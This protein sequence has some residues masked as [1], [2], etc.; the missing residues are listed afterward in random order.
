MSVP[1]GRVGLA[2]VA[3]VVVLAVGGCLSV[4]AGSDGGDAS[5]TTAQVTPTTDE[6]GD[7]PA[8]PPSD[9]GQSA[10]VTRV[11]DGDT[12][13]VELADGTVEK[14]RL[15]GVDT[16]E[17]YSENTPD[18]YGVPDTQAGRDC[19]GRYGD[20][21]SEFAVER[22]AG[23]EVR[24]VPDENLDERGYYGRLLA[25][26]YVDGESFN[27]RLIQEGYARVFE[28]DFTRRSAYE[29][30][31]RAARDADRGL[32]EC[33]TDTDAGTTVSE[34]GLAVATVNADAEG[35]DGENLNDE[36]VVFENVGSESLSLQG[37]TVTDEAGK[38]YTFP[39]VT[40]APGERVT[41]H[42]GAGTDTETD[43]YWGATSPVWNNGGDTV[44]V[45]DEGGA[46]VVQ[47]SY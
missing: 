6:T 17:V 47:E 14:V 30:A 20:R 34:S 2:V 31:Q 4:G 9:A 38:Q 45:T 33:A 18:E 42:T 5:P 13:E 8:E 12:V 3:V 24:I 11:V 1:A 39:A 28:S 29:D 15:I 22:L 25:Y 36:Y 40:L 26:V 23:R 10:T 35:R 37:W 44:T 43:L 46:V 19:L 27:Y 41:L 7:A 21:A 32:W 16:P